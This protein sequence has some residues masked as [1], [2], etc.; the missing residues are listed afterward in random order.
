M[1]VPIDTREVAGRLGGFPQQVADAVSGLSDEQLDTPYRAGGWTVRQV[2]HHLADAHINGYVRTKLALTEGFPVLRTYEQD[3]WSALPDAAL[4]IGP[5]MA[6]LETLHARWAALVSLLDD[7]S[8][9]RQAYHPE[10]GAM[11]VAE[12][13][14]IYVRHCDNHLGQILDLKRR[15]GW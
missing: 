15:N 4:P 9:A 5:S 3:A 11:S 12:L 13:L 14:E 7:A 10:S 1:S 8:L 2:V 6:L